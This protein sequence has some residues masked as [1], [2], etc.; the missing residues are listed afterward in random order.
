MRHQQKALNVV[1]FL[2]VILVPR[3]SAKYKAPAAVNR[4]GVKTQSAADGGQN[5]AQALA[6]CS[7]LSCRS[8]VVELLPFTD[9]LVRKILI[10]ARFMA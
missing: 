1:C 8:Q 3:L 10:S 7:S 2:T 6:N 4:I 5:R 9:R